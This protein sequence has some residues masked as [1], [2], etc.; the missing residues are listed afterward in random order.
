MN[1]LFAL[2]QSKLKDKMQ[3]AAIK[4]DL[5]NFVSFQFKQLSRKHL[6]IPIQ[7]YNL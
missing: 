4:K 3:K 6:R 2:K 5:V 1:N 7:L